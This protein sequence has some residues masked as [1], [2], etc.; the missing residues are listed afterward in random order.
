ME[1][2]NALP[3]LQV[4]ALAAETEIAVATVVFGWLFGDP[5]VPLFDLSDYLIEMTESGV[6]IDGGYLDFLDARITGLL[7]GPIDFVPNRLDSQFLLNDP[8]ID[9]ELFL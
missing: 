9:R 3:G 2:I 5:E 7:G 8:R 1:Q 4:C 6:G